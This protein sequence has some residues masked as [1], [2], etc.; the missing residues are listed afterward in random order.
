MT[1]VQWQSGIPV[2]VFPPQLALVAT[3]LAQKL[4]EDRK[5]SWTRRHTTEV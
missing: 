2:T 1:I 4:A 5:S 3:V